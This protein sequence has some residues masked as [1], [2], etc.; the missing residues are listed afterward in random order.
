MN[1]KRRLEEVLVKISI[2][3][4][5]Q[6]QLKRLTNSEDKLNAISKKAEEREMKKFF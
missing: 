2:K 6:N 4:G 3:E 1:A 5:L